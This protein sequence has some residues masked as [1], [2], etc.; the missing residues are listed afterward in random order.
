MFHHARQVA[1]SCAARKN[2]HARLRAGPCTDLRGDRPHAALASL[3][4]VAVP[5]IMSQH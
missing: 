1:S 5:F 4:V 2:K 3:V